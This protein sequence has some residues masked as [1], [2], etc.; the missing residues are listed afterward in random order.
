MTI[1]KKTTIL[2]RQRKAAKAFGS[3]G[4]LVLIGAGAPVPKPGGQD[5]TYPFLPHPEYY[6]LSGSRRSGGVLAYDP[7]KGWVHFVRRADEAEKLWEGAP[8]VPEGE[9]VKDL[10]G[11]LRSRAGKPAVVLGNGAGLPPGPVKQEPSLSRTAQNILDR[12]RRVKDDEELAYI[13]KAIGATAARFRKAREIIKQGMTERRVQIEL[14]AEMLRHG[15][16][17]TGFGSI[18][19]AGDHSSVLH[20]EPGGRA[21]GKKDLVLIDAGAEVLEYCADVTRTLPAGGKFTPEQRAIYDLVLAAQLEA[22]SLCRPGTEW[23]AVHRAAAA[24]LCRGLVDLGVLKGPVEEL[25]ETGAAALF[26]PHG[27]GHMLGLRVR[28]VGGTAPGRA[29]GRMCC[30]TR[31][32]VDLPLE[33]GFLMTV[34]PGLYFV[35]AILDNAKLRFKHKNSVVWAALDRWRPIGGVRIE[36][37]V[38]ITSGK[39]R[40]LTSEIPK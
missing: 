39:P 11:W 16:S 28:D 9:D 36:D 24:V 30:G 12:I 26:F 14:E 33:E 40:V 3:N 34:E 2:Q 4:P 29:E 22:I 38:L 31:V 32:R 13:R 8:E 20:F 6:W 21:I 10:P 7:G 19:G 27:V 23:H 1:F 25:L 37:D 17:G 15:A 35:P 5:Q 18:V